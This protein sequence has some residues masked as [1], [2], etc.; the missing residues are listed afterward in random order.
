MQ[1][2][3]CFYFDP[4]VATVIT[5]VESG[6]GYDRN[7]RRVPLDAP[8]WVGK[9]ARG[10]GKTLLALAVRQSMAMVRGAIRC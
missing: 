4:C 9:Q 5:W 1:Y 8:N 6:A 10:L 3:P 7:I 2:K